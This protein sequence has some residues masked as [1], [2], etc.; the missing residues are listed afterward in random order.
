MKKQD[1][2][3]RGLEYGLS[4]PQIE[5]V[6]CRV[7]NISKEELFT[8]AEISAKY[9]YEVQQI[10]F[11]MQNG[12][13]EEYILERANFYGRDFHVDAGVLIPRNDTEVLVSVAIKKILE[14]FENVKSMHYID[15][16]T[17]SACI[18]ISI[19]E[20]IHPLKFASVYALEQS[21]D[22]LEVA[23]KNIEHFS[24]GQIGLL[25][26]DLLAAV[27]HNDFYKKTLCI[28]ANLPYIKDGDYENMDPGV[29]KNEPHTALF[30]GPDTG[31]ELYE[32]LIKQCF[33]M[34]E[35]H[36]LEEIH[37]FI[38]IGFD[39]KGVSKCFLEEMWLKFEY[40]M[41]SS[42]IERVIYISGFAWV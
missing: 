34:R 9:I 4:L 42:N 33:Q 8:Q 1:Y 27:F 28:T 37:M 12:A 24:E 10:F 41:D 13:S 22:A 7:M 39:Q 16:G 23:R 25:Q 38:E 17:G 3:D 14:S 29:V 30:W 15:V 35:V 40:F 19:M 11:D 6:L 26:S 5:N 20:E 18:P 2:I 31:F 32:K 21:S 36:K